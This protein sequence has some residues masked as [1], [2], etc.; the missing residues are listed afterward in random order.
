M[1]FGKARGKNPAELVTKAHQFFVRL[2]YESNQERV[3]EEIA[4]ALHSMKV[5]GS[6]GASSTPQLAGG[7]QQGSG[8][9]LSP[10]VPTA[11]AARAQEAMFGEDEASANKENALIIVHEACRSDL[12]SDI[13]SYLSERRP[14]AAPALQCRRRR[15]RFPA[16][17]P[18]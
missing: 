7:W 18:A 15:H 5:G 10:P 1:V 9:C 14:P 3:S 12:L 17:L 8:G 16:R 4:K 6:A 2:P 13:V 11:A